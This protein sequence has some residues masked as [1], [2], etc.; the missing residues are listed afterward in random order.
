[1]HPEEYLQDASSRN[2]TLPQHDEL[3]KIRDILFGA[4]SNEFSQRILDLEQQ[5][6]RETAQ[7]RQTMDERLRELETIFRQEITQLRTAL[8][9]ETNA[10]SEALALMERDFRK[11]IEEMQATM[12]DAFT[13]H[14]NKLTT[15]TQQRTQAIVGL[16]ERLAEMQADKADRRVLSSLLNQMAEA[17]SSSN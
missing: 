15:E 6:L 14:G 13:H 9:A 12:D 4:Q 8:S 17:L 5:L 10:R 16:T 2:G 3:G 1:M 7:I 11:T